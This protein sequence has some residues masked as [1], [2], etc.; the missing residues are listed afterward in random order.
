MS[1]VGTATI[2]LPGG[3]ATNNFQIQGTPVGDL[4]TAP[5]LDTLT[6]G[7]NADALHVHAGM[8]KEAGEALNSGALVSVAR[9]STDSNNPK[10]WNCDITTTPGS[11]LNSPLPSGFVQAAYADGA[12]AV[13]Y[14][15]GTEATVPASQWTGGIPAKTSIG[16][17]V[18]A[19]A[20]AGQ[21]SL[22]APASGSGDYRT[23]VGI[24]S[25][26]DGSTT[27]KVLVQIGD[28]VLMA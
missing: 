27:S 1:F 7:S 6:D 10:V 23:K 19:S 28:S 12:T 14:T 3:A 16:V 9:E 13:V 2:N 26:T 21:V 17:P 4:V 18:Y 5:N 22:T 8:S 15:A 24:L 11:D 25:D 20:T